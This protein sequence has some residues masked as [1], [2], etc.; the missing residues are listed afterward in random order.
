M[1]E[2]V[3][4]VVNE[5]AGTNAGVEALINAPTIGGGRKRAQAARA[6]AA[7]AVLATGEGPCSCILLAVAYCS[8]LVCG[9]QSLCV[10]GARLCLKCPGLLHT[11]RLR[12][13]RTTIQPLVFCRRL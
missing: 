1:W 9:S 10:P 8:L 4:G 2:N 7:E 12:T 3:I 13:R 5:Q 11:R 6:A